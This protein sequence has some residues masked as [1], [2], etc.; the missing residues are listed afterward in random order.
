ML[1]KKL[2]IILTLSLA[3]CGTQLPAAPKHVQYGAYAS[4]NPPGFYGVDSASK[5][6]VYRPFND[7]VMSGAQC[8]TTHDYAQWAAWIESVKRIAK[9]KCK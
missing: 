4:V 6:R 5:E 1:K 3:G 2:L 8:L 7:P 9:E